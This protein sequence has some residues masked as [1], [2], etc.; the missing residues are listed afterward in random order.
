R[1]DTSQSNSTYTINVSSVGDDDVND[2]IELEEEIEKG[3][4]P[5]FDPIRLRFDSFIHFATPTNNQ[6][7]S[8]KFNFPFGEAL[9]KLISSC[10]DLLCILVEKQRRTRLVDLVLW[11]PL[12]EMYRTISISLVGL[13][14][15]MF[16]FGYENTFGFGYY[17]STND[18]KIVILIEDDSRTCFEIYSLN[19]NSWERGTL[20]WHISA[21]HSCKYSGTF[22]NAALY[23]RIDRTVDTKGPYEKIL[24]DGSKVILRFDLVDDKFSLILPPNDVKIINWIRIMRIPHMKKLDP[25]LYSAPV[26]FHESGEVLLHLKDI[27]YNCGKKTI[28]FILTER[29]DFQKASD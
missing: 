27:F 19:T 14:E 8:I 23:W 20:P 22:V 24:F 18:Y 4:R 29:G 9:H 26:L 10:N 17:H 13:F 6:L 12:T 11:N 1:M 3:L 5:N 15:N 2:I 16:G 7:K 21:L 25:R 28:L